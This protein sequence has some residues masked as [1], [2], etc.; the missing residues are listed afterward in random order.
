MMGAAPSTPNLMPAAHRDHGEVG[1]GEEIVA[2]RALLLEQIEPRRA[3]LALADRY[4]IEHRIDADQLLDVL[5]ELV[6]ALDRET[7][8][9]HSG[10]QDRGAEIVLDPPRHDHQ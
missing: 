8:V 5:L 10:R 7:D 2:D 1:V 4:R 3:L 6:D 9:V